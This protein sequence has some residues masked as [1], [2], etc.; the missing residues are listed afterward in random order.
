[1]FLAN[2]WIWN[3]LRGVIQTEMNRPQSSSWKCQV[4]LETNDLL[5]RVFEMAN[6][7]SLEDVLLGSKLDNELV[8]SCHRRLQHLRPL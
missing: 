5:L 8:I 1:M 4:L 7:W 3:M 2:A 6:S